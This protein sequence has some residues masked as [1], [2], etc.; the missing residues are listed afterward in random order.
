MIDIVGFIETFFQLKYLVRK[1]K[2]E[3]LFNNVNIKLII[4]ILDKEKCN[5]CKSCVDICPTNSLK[6]NDGKLNFDIT[7]CINCYL[8]IEL[9]PKNALIKK[10]L[11]ERI[12]L[13]NT[14]N[15]IIEYSQKLFSKKE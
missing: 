11:T 9:C 14:G 6:I 4:P 12:V 1:E 10:D 5:L 3:F 2:K 8:C 13:K 7:V 15:N